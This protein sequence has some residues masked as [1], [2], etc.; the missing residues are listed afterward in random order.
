MKELYVADVA[1]FENQIVVGFFAVLTRQLRSRKDGGQYLAATLGDQTGQVESRMWDNFTDSSASFEEGDIVK[2]KGEV[3]RY[4]GRVQL[5]LEKVRRA[6]PEEFDLGA[7][8]RC[9]G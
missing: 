7:R 6:N 9:A 1:K 8:L 2:V 4:N 5:N 3:C